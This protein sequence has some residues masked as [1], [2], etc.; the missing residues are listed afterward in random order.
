[1]PISAIQHYMS[2]LDKRQAEKRM[3]DADAASVPHL[4]EDHHREWVEGVR[5]AIGGAR[6]TKKA[7][8]V[9]PRKLR[10]VGI[11]MVVEA[12]PPTPFG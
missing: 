4:D 7:E 10:G 12:P 2:T 6:Q 3:M 9:T 11:K 5:D 1:M 8:V